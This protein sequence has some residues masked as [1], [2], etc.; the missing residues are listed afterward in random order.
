MAQGSDACVG[1]YISSALNI[2]NNWSLKLFLPRNVGLP[3]QNIVDKN[4]E[5]D[6]LF[7]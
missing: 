5:L 4:T 7:Q 1:L 3:Q 6:D 2:P